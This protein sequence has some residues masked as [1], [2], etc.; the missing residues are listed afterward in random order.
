[1][2]SAVDLFY[3]DQAAIVRD[4]AELVT[5]ADHERLTPSMHPR[6]RSEHIAGR[7][8]LRYALAMRTGRRPESFRIE[9]SPHGK[10]TCVDG[11][12]FSISHSGAFV[13]CAVADDV[14]VGV[15][16]ETGRLPSAL[17]DLVNRYFTA[18]EAAWLAADPEPRFRMLWV[19]K[20][21]Y[22]K[23][24]GLGL[25]G[26]LQSLECLVDPPKIHAKTR[27]AVPQLALFAAAQFDFVAVAALGESRIAV[28]PHAYS[29]NASTDASGLLR[30]V[31]TS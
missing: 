31:A 8:L 27:A 28:T 4:A 11:P 22:L 18:A 19:L 25:A 23:A 7:A 26:G 17:M 12:W 15:D 5:A 29:P 6:R 3:A 10:P 1:M 21:A 13:V 16:L 2:R 9:V 30:L 24:L 20:E 14:E